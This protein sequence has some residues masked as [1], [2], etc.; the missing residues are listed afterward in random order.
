MDCG[1]SGNFLELDYEK[2]G[3]LAQHSWWSHLWRLLSMYDVT[4]QLFSECYYPL[5]RKHDVGLMNILVERGVF[6]PAE[7]IRI[8]RVRHF[9]G[10]LVLSELTHC[11]GIT[12]RK[13][14]LS[15]D[16]IQSVEG[17]HRYPI[18]RPT[19]SDFGLW[20]TALFTVFSTTS[21][22]Y[23]PLGKYL[24]HPPLPHEWLYSSSNDLLFRRSSAPS[25]S[26]AI[27]VKSP[28]ASV[29]RRNAVQ[30][31]FSCTVVD[32][33]VATHSLTDSSVTVH[34]FAPVPSPPI[35]LSLQEVIDSFEDHT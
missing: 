25:S 1:L 4:L 32:P 23:R 22:L 29:S 28:S 33:P 31:T 13:E 9:K 34:S 27:Y 24:R 5:P 19:A 21:T 17:H 14:Y 30:F 15:E 2:Y 10:V 16:R 7:L 35:V 26:V 20:R 3:F 11:D 18:E 12:L 6:A 8:N